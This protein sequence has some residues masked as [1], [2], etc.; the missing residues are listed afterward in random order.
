MDRDI[1]E[2]ITIVVL[3][4]VG[5]WIAAERASDIDLN[6]KLEIVD[7]PKETNHGRSE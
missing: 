1:G 4:C 7:Q 5:S 2:I 3:L 6:I